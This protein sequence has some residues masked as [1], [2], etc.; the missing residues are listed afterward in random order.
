[1]VVEVSER[2]AIASLAPYCLPFS[3]FALAARYL[4]PLW[5]EEGLEDL[6]GWEGSEGWG[7]AEDWDGLDG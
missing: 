6:D 7:G 1:M 2:S 4:W 5:C 3:N